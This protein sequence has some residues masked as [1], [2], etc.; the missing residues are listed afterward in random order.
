VDLQRLFDNLLD[1]QP[2]IQRRIRILEDHL[3]VGPVL[4]HFLPGQRSKI[5]DARPC[6]VQDLPRDIDAVAHR[7]KNIDDGPPDGR[8]TA[9]GLSNQAER[10]ALLERE[11]HTGDGV[12]LAR[13]AKQQAAEHREP[14]V[15]VLDVKDG[16]HAP[17]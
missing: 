17:R 4:T 9:A 3:N 2:G 14:D 16:R 13:F 8:F 10:L 7:A 6:V 1:A 5:D 11:R 12:H 15:Q